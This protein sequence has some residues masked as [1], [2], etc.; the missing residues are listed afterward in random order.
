[1]KHASLP[2]IYNLIK[3]HTQGSTMH[4]QQQQQRPPFVHQKGKRKYNQEEIID[5]VD[6][7]K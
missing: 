3:T 1:M 4:A 6:L 5:R 7:L 2:T